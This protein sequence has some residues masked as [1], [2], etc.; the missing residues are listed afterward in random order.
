MA[1]PLGTTEKLQKLKLFN[2]KIEVLRR[3]NFIQQV[4]QPNH[5]VTINF[6]RPEPLTFERRGADEEALH[7]FA[8]TLRFFVQPRDGITIEQIAKIYE[9]L[10]VEDEAKRSARAAA[11]SLDGYLD[12][13]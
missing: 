12:R 10:P 2:E 1:L 4:F 7:A 3:R 5:G 13:A 6:G 8:T 11:D 9:S